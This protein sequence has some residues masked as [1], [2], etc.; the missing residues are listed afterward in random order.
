MAKNS[1]ENKVAG[2]MAFYRKYRPDT[3]GKVL[4]Q[5]HIVS[6]LK[7]AVDGGTTVHAYL[8]AG[9]RGT[10]KTSVARILARE[11][12][13]SDNDLYEIDAASNRGIDDVRALK[14][15]VQT[16]PFESKYKVYIVDEVH[17]L[18]K[19]AFNALLKTLEEPPKHVVF[20]LATTELGKLPETIIS[21]CQVFNFKK[22]TEQVLKSLVLDI[23]EAEGVKLDAPTADLIAVLGE[24]SFRD[25]TGILQKVLNFA[26]GKKI[27]REEVEAITGAP[28]TTLINDFISALGDKDLEKGLSVTHQAVGQNIDMKV[29]LKLILKR[30]RV[31][32]LLKFAENTAKEFMEDMA[33]DD[34]KF[35]TT[36]TKEHGTNISSTTLVVLLEAYGQ[37]DYA[38]IPELPLE[39][40]LIKLISNE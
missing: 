16:L 11:L 15:A 36:F 40:A 1:N 2:N 17:M 18:T 7:S 35:I 14:E 39:L 25:T 24:G 37:I 33:E 22:P 9:S 34:R 26:N 4:G 8:F 12:G 19:E 38:F 30:L 28:S 10:G 21:R 32:L 29:Y 23:G 3:F 13:T 6:V 27:T 5:D 31:A 20:I